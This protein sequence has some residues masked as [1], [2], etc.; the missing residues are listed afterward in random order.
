[1]VVDSMEDVHSPS[2]SWGCL[3]GRDLPVNY[4]YETSAEPKLSPMS[5]PI[6]DNLPTAEDLEDLI[7]QKCLSISKVAAVP[8]QPGGEGR[9][10]G[11]PGSEPNPGDRIH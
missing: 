2:E 7:L 11:R 8:D 3:V 10:P 4:S 9:L 6:L 5:S 1:M